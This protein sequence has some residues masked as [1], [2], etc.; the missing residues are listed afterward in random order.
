MK[1]KRLDSILT[2][3]I[4]VETVFN[5]LQTIWHP[6]ALC[7]TLGIKSN[8]NLSWEK[9]IKTKTPIEFFAGKKIIQ[10]YY[11]LATLAYNLTH[12]LIL[13]QL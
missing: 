12:F 8:E 1:V 10:R 6:R 11:L 4:F 13:F 2:I 9:K 7:Y 5:S 3:K